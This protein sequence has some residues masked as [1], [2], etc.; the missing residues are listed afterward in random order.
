[1]GVMPGAEGSG[2][3]LRA[4][5][6]T[7]PDGLITIDQKSAILSF[8]PAAERLF[9]Y[10][11]TEVVGTP[12][13]R[14]MPE[15]YGQ[16]HDGFV[17]RYMQTGEKRIIG[18]GREVLGLRRDGSVFPMELAVGEAT[19][20]EGRVF[21][22]F[23]RDISARRETERRLHELQK[24]LIHVTRLSAMGEM[25]SAL[26]H[27][28]NQPLTAVVNYAQG[29]RRL[30]GKDDD[31]AKPRVDGLLEK[32][33]VQATR[34][35]EIIHQL[36]QFLAKG[37]TERVLT[38]IEPLVRDACAL[39]LIGTESQGI[40]AAIDID[41]DLSPALL[42]RVQIHQVVTNLIRN[43]VDALEEVEVRRLRVQV[44][45]EPTAIAVTVE[46][47]GRGISPLIEPR[48]FQPFM[49]TKSGGMGIGLSIC[50][51][52]VESH[53]GH[54]WADASAMGGAA[55]HVTVPLSRENGHQSEAVDLRS[56]HR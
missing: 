42:D 21:A 37:E 19:V 17:D 6:E 23:I 8:N 48:L 10:R 28:L 7:A 50:R 51:T 45:Q 9:G 32:M 29:A 1:M 54:I 16:R 36:R 20:N 40:S 43:A 53:G 56:R 11:E 33:V 35:G 25:A 47:S 46:D 26:A 13:T 34:A 55:F 15:P 24:E 44:R 12:V 3:V 18:I 41:D 39:A 52:I 27:E 31:T 38:D 30:L 14:L 2:A 5:I 4:I 49:T 22:A